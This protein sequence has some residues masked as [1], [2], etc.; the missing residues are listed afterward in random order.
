MGWTTPTSSSQRARWTLA[1][2]LEDLTEVQEFVSV[3][4]IS[5]RLLP[6]IPELEIGQPLTRADVSIGRNGASNVPRL[7]SL[8]PPGTNTYVLSSNKTLVLL[9]GQDLHQWRGVSVSPRN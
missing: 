8:G 9:I 5:E 7:A 3:P 1:F 6:Q 4:D 2:L